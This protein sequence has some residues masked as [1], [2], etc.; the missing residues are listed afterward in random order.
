MTW[1][2]SVVSVQRS[3]TAMMSTEFRTAWLPLS[4]RFVKDSRGHEGTE[5]DQSL[6]YLPINHRYPIPIFDATKHKCHHNL[7]RRISSHNKEATVCIFFPPGRIW[8]R[9]L[10]LRDTDAL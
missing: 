4:M 10:F 6:G 1:S 8:W 2:E 3:W 9:A 5:L 7:T